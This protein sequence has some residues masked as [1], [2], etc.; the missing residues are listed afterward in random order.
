MLSS[1][2]QFEGNESIYALYVQLK[3]MQEK[4]VSV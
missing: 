1:N 2:V 3:I 4:G